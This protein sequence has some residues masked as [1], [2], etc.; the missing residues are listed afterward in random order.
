[1]MY[2][3]YPMGYDPQVASGPPTKDLVAMGI[4]WS[5][6][7]TKK[8][9]LMEKDAIESD[10]KPPVGRWYTKVDDVIDVACS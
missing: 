6:E 2:L 9:Q 7:D 1:M 4:S 8:H 3:V 5:P 10:E